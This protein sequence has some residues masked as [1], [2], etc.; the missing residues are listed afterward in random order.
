VDAYILHRLV[1]AGFR[2]GMIFDDKAL[3][4]LFVASRGI[5]RLI[6]ILCH[7]ALMVAYGQ[8]THFINEDML[9]M[10]I[11]DTEDTQLR[12]RRVPWW[13]RMVATL[14]TVAVLVSISSY[15]AVMS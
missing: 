4:R 14:A 15:V 6:N 2:N 3:A 10:A 9:R 7:K 5:P 12:R 13:R 8:G 1:V 11:S